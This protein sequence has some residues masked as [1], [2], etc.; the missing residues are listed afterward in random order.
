M[1][2]RR[3]K[4]RK[5]RTPADGPDATAIAATA[6]VAM[7]DLAGLPDSQFDALRAALAERGISFDDKLEWVFMREQDGRVTA[8][9]RDQRVGDA[10]VETVGIDRFDLDTDASA[11][12]FV[13]DDGN[14]IDWNNLRAPRK[15][16]PGEH[17]VDC[18]LM[19]C[20]KLLEGAS[21]DEATRDLTEPG[22][23]TSTEATQMAR[24]IWA[25]MRN[26]R[27]FEFDASLFEGL[28]TDEVLALQRGLDRLA[29]EEDGRAN[30]WFRSQCKRF[31]FPEERPFEFCFF[32]FSERVYVPYSYWHARVARSVVDHIQRVW[33]L[34]YVL[35]P[36]EIWELVYVYLKGSKRVMWMQT[37]VVADHFLVP[38]EVWNQNEGWVNEASFGPLIATSLNDHVLT[39]QTVVKEHRPSTNQRYEFGRVRRKAKGP[40]FIPRPYYVVPVRDKLVETRERTDETAVGRQLSYRHDREGHWRT[41]VRRGPLPLSDEKRA[42]FLDAGFSVFTASPPSDAFTLGELLKKGHG[43]KRHGEWLAVKH[44]WIE[45]KIIGDPSLPY[46]P[47]VRVPEEDLKKRR[48]A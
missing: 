26:A 36:H 9:A 4:R 44:T 11:A 14:P 13:G 45:D 46:I 20:R 8:Q 34:G 33:L 5:K 37:E 1:S 16:K 41:Y 27:V 32:A 25:S 2:K 47:A 24:R 42:H 39:H 31:A 3:K 35:G 21:D 15:H 29:D 23:P 43:P 22:R 48:S 30:A 12:G 10:M 19:A 18:Y 28:V 7:R 6:T 17:A 40:G 38:V